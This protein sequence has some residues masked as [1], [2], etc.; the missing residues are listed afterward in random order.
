MIN[1]KKEG[2]IILFFII[3]ISIL[4]IPF[5]YGGFF[6]FL[7][8]IGNEITGL[9][10]SNTTGMTVRIGNTQ[11]VVDAITEINGTDEY[12]H[13]IDP[14]TIT[15]DGVISIQF[16]F[17]ASD[18]D[19]VGNLD[20]TS[21]TAYINDSTNFYEFT[22]SSCVWIADLNTTTAEY[23]C[24]VDIWYYGLAGDWTLNI[25]INDSSGDSSNN[26]ADNITNFTLGSSTCMMMAPI[27]LTYGT[28]G[29]TDSNKTA[30]NDP[31][32]LNNTCNSNFSTI[33]VT[34]IDFMG[35]TIDDEKI[36]AN[37]TMVDIAT[38]GSQCTD[39]NCNECN[40]TIMSNNT[41]IQVVGAYLD[42]GNKSLEDNSTGQETLY[43]CMYDLPDGI[44]Q[45]QF[46][47]VNASEWTIAVS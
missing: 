13:Y 20:D 32:V 25:S 16:N 38:G 8:E 30:T 14:Q 11:P 4:I 12:D 26:Y 33:E 5:I 23:N 22:N 3:F 47:T 17:T 15:E 40:G 7:G 19:G 31:V 6:N 29:L 2:K 35:E 42:P 10:T 45:Q 41:A 1:M 34:A 46:S 39:E 9:I 37:F 43:F 36:T 28:I 18:P 44:S 24:T 21:G 27:N